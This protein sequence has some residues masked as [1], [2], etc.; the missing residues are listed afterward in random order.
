MSA[1]PARGGQAFPP[2]QG[3]LEISGGYPLEPPTEGSASAKGGQALC[4][5]PVEVAGYR[6]YSTGRAGALRGKWHSLDWA[7]NLGS[8]GDHH[9][10]PHLK[11]QSGQL[12]LCHRSYSE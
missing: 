4:I 2:A 11:K 9:V 5:P 12:A 10:V 3:R 7:R 1:V 6:Y 8:S